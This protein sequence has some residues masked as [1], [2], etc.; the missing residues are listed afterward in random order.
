MFLIVFFL[1]GRWQQIVFCII[2]DHGLGKDLVLVLKAGSIFKAAVHEGSDLIH[3]QINVG[4]IFGLD[5]AD[6]PKTLHYGIDKIACIKCHSV[7]L[8]L[9]AV[10][11][12]NAHGIHSLSVEAYGIGKLIIIS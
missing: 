12:H 3:I 4:D 2:I 11:D 7:I 6:T 5:K 1:N 8:R 9:S 10:Y